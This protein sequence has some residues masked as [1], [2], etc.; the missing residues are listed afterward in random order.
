MPR[1]LNG[2][3]V[4]VVEDEFLLAH[5][6]RMALERVGATIVGPVDNEPAAFAI[7][8]QDG[9]DVVALDWNLRGKR[10]LRMTRYLKDRSIPFVIVTGYDRAAL[11][12][13]VRTAPFVQKPFGQDEL[14]L[15]LANAVGSLDAR[16]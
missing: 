15:A 4:L 5:Q 8:M 14:V 7:L 13:E 9:A 11:P 12:T 2:K 1:R 3:R 10:P 16:L 6:E